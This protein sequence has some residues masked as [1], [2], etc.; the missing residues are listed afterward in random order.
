MV[1]Y[2]RVAWNVK[3]ITLLVVFETLCTKRNTLIERDMMADNT[4]FAN[5]NT[6]AMVNSKILSY[7]SAGVYVDTSLGV[8][9]FG[10][11]TR[12]DGNI[13]HV[14]GVGNAIVGHGIDH[15]ITEDYLTV[16][17]C[18]RIVVEHGFHIGIEQTLQ[19]WQFI[20]KF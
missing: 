1:F 19:L 15:W 20:D 13:L 9:L 8:C 5:H 17:F 6:R 12:Y 18:G 11:D 2:N 7:G 16:G 3:H 10:D 14:E 4:G